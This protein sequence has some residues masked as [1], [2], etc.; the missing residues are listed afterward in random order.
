MEM[1]GVVGRDVADRLVATLPYDPPEEVSTG[2]GSDD[3]A[4][5]NGGE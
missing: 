3:A 5:Q 4:R 2:P 1:A